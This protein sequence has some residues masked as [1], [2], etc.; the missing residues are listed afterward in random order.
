MS[1]EILFPVGRMVGGSLSKLFQA[2][3][4]KGNGKLKAGTNEPLMRL[5]F[6]V[7]FAKGQETHWA[8][9]LWGKDIWEEAAAGFPGG[10]Y[11]APTFAFKVID[12]D[13][14]IPNKKGKKP[15][16]KEGYPGHWVVWFGQSWMCKKVDATGATE[17]TDPEAIKP[18]YFVQVWA[19]CLGNKSTESPGVYLNPK[20]AALSG[21]GTPIATSEDVDT[22]AAGFGGAPLP[23]GASTTP[24]GM[25]TPPD[26][27]PAG[28]PSGPPAGNAP[29]PPPPK[30]VEK[31][32]DFLTPK[33]MTDKAAG[34]T[35][36]S[37]I[38]QGWTVDQL[39]AEG[40]MLAPAQ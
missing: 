19:E 37:F 30:K 7:A 39:I 15:C 31:A 16:D 5:N 38:A 32:E 18:G 13:S 34:A 28:P 40:Y 26:A 1:R 6:G 21:Y 10:E 17:L 33:T 3:D 23:A 27:P 9:T 4:S 11:N 14:Q 35:Y 24:V 8:Q 25:D 29:P 22:T 20:A 36:E 2:T 12:G